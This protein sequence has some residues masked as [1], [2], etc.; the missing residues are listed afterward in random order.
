MNFLRWLR[1]SLAYFRNPRWDTGIS[2]P[3]LMDFI[4]THPP[5]RALDVGCGSGT[6]AITLAQRGWQVVGVDLAASAISIARTKARKAKVKAQ[7]LVANV[8]RL[9]NVG[10]PF[11]LL[12]D[13]GCFHNLT[14]IERI[15]FVKNLDNLLTP[16]GFYLNYTFFKMPD[17]PKPGITD[18][19]LQRLSEHLSLVWRRDGMDKN[20]RKS[21]WLCWE[22]KR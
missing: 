18:Q 11:N 19:D 21:A 1:F 10:E 8:S 14:E 17:N 7:F 4:A 15:R 2:P 16:G 9:A 20:G 13:I 22:K 6:N 12:L 3:E 5:G